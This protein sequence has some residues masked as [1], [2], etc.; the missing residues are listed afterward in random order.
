VAQKS[1]AS[2]RDVLIETYA[3]N[4]RMNQLLL[5]H[6][7]PKAWRA[8]LPGPRHSGRTI[9]AIFA[10]LH[11]SRLVWLRKSAPHLACPAPLDPYR[12]TMNQAATAHKKSAEQC[13]RMLSEA[14]SS[15]PQRK[16]T[17]FSRGSWT[18]TWPAGG[19]MFAY[20]FSHEA[21]HRGQIIQ[22]AHQ[23]GFRLPPQ[24][25]GGIWQWDKLWKQHGFSTRPR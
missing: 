6:L 20:M 14:L 10:H 4:D 12:C 13:H 8:Q 5:G 19:A 7:D 1:Q 15:D 24:A 11:N 25:W 23:I 3:V 9:A 17:E 21:H 16:V 2:L 18:R 22:L